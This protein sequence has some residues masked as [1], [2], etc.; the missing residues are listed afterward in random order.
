MGHLSELAELLD[1]A[2]VAWL[3]VNSPP[4]RNGIV[5]TPAHYDADNEFHDT[6]F[7]ERSIRG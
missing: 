1:D 3:T 5:M 2:S 4:S 6:P 7:G